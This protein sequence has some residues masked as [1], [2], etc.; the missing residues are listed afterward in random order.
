VA[1][2][3]AA[4]LPAAVPA[5]MP[6]PSAVPP[7]ESVPDR[8]A[9]AEVPAADI[10]PPAERSKAAV[11]WAGADGTLDPK[12][13][14]AIQAFM[15]P[16]DAQA[17]ASEVKDGISG[18][19]GS[20]P[21][22]RLQVEF[23]PDTGSLVLRGHVPDPDRAAPVLAALQAQVGDSIRVRS[24]LRILPPPQCGALAGI[25]GVG[26]PQSNDQSSNP[27]IVGA[28]SFARE[29]HFTTGQPLDLDLKGTDYPAWVYVDYFD[30]GGQVIHLIPNERIPLSLVAPDAPLAALRAQDGKGPL[31]IVFGP[32]YG[33]EIVVAFAASATL[34][35]GLRPLTEPA[36][37]YLDFL[38]AR[39]AAAR[40]ADHGFKGEWVYF[41]VSTSAR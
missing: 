12:S 11:A 39:V 41:F 8:A 40:E 35:D 22:A 30:A 32:P 2:P 5:A 10:P 34:Y 1:V 27:R 28:D 29:F 25:A 9:A 21:C 3:A 16:G 24:D 37:H 6:A 36:A 33:Q 4:D 7:A 31:G 14:D 13:L 17:A 20:V 23:D 18:L 26:L 38:H 19:L 15:R